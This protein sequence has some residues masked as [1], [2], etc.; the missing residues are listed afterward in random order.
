MQEVIYTIL[1]NTRHC[2]LT[3]DEYMCTAGENE[4]CAVVNSMVVPKKIK[5]KII[6]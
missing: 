3:K 4:K 5:H 1:Q 6:I 2:L